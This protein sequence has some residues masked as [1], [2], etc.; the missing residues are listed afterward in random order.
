M[1]PRAYGL[2]NFLLHIA[3]RIKVLHEFYRHR[4]MEMHE[5]RQ[6]KTSSYG[7]HTGLL[8]VWSMRVDMASW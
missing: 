4:R 8:Q 1:I 6:R 7:M 5:K 3:F 2:C